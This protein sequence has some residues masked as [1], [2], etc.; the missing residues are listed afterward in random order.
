MK[1]NS[2]KNGTLSILTCITTLIFSSYLNAEVVRGPNGN[3]YEVVTT[4]GMTWHEAEFEASERTF[5]GLPGHLVTLTSKQENDFVFRLTQKTEYSDLQFWLGG[6][7]LPGQTSPQEGWVWVNDE[8]PI[9]QAGDN[10][11]SNWAGIEPN[12]F[13]G[14]GED[15]EEDFLTIGIFGING[16]NDVPVDWNAAGPIAG[17]IVEYEQSE[18]RLC[19]RPDSPQSPINARSQGLLQVALYSNDDF[20]NDDINISSIKFGKTGTEASVIRYLVQDLNKDG[21]DDLLLFFSTPNC[22]F[23]EGDKTAILTGKLKSGLSF[24]A[25][26]SITVVK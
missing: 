24:Y 21:E 18:V 13:P 17:Y 4:L 15:G 14:P 19:V 2:I 20:Q 16:W 3:F 11:Y 8:G 26:D 6:Y 1:G 12:D 23:S 5:N 9:P 10:G 22:G 25:E 7:Q